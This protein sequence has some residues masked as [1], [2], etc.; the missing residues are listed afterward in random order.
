MIKFVAPAV[1]AWPSS[2]LWFV[3]GLEAGLS[4][5]WLETAT[6][7]A[8]M[9]GLGAFGSVFL[10]LE[11]LTRKVLAK[12]SLRGGVVSGFFWFGMKFIVPLGLFFYALRRGLP[13]FFVV[14]GLSVGLLSVAA[15]LFV[16]STS[17]D[18]NY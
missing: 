4:R 16:F 7:L 12:A 5:F 3:L 9:V 2:I 10:S 6:W 11:A 13:I 18:E 15:V 14:V 8:F 17:R 1:L